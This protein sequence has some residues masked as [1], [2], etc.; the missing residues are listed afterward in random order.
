MSNIIKPSIDNE[1]LSLN[2]EY[3]KN[4]STFNKLEDRSPFDGMLDKLGEVKLKLAIID[5]PEI[6]RSGNTLLNPLDMK[7]IYNFNNG[8]VCLKWVDSPGGVIRPSEVDGKWEKIS[9]NEKY[10]PEER[11]YNEW[12]ISSRRQQVNLSHPFIWADNK[13]YCGFNYI[14][15]VGSMVIVGFRKQGLPFVLGFLP[16]HYKI[17]YPVL[18]PGEMVLKGYGN[19]YIHNRWSDKLDLKAWSVKNE[20]DLDDPKGEKKNI[21]DCTLW[22]RLNANDRYIELIAE[23][24]GNGK[25]TDKFNKYPIDADGN[26]KTSVVIRPRDITIK[27]SNDKESS[28]Y[29]QNEKLIQL[30]VKEYILNAENTTINSKY[31]TTINSKDLDINTQNITDITSTNNN[32]NSNNNLNINSSNKNTLSSGS[33]SD[34]LAGNNVN[35]KGSKVY[36]N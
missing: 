8:C 34:I 26:H 5:N 29:F 17:C 16:T 14:P 3:I 15:P 30:D 19:N 12:D 24:S 31:T 1:N 9:K 4:Q 21:S 27:S 25:V 7:N 11:E 18:K 6:I 28:S 35:I 13:N 22:I 33:N 23:E 20:K 10:N 36:L 32:I 2:R